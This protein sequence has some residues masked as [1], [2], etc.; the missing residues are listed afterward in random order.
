LT[1]HFFLIALILTFGPGKS[2]PPK[3]DIYVLGD[4]DKDKGKGKE[5]QEAESRECKWISGIIVS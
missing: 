3:F 4:E 2:Q 1:R 5:Q